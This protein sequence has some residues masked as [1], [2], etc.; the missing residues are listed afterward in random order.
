VIG[1]TVLDSTDLVRQLWLDNHFYGQIASVQYKN[2]GDELTM[3]GGWT[4]YTGTHYGNIQWAQFG[5][6]EPGYQYYSYPALKTDENIYAKWQ[7]QLNT[8]WQTFADVQ[9][10]HVYHRM[11]GFEGA[12]TLNVSRTFNFVNPKAGI[13][14][15]KKGWQ[16]FFS[17]AL[18]NK[19]P[20]RDD[21]QASLISQPKAEMLHDFELGV[22]KKNSRYSYGA[23]VYYML[24]KDQLVLTGKQ[25]D[26][27]AYTRVNVPN[28][29]RLGIELQGGYVFD[30][31]INATANLTLSKNKVKDFTEYLDDYDNGGQVA[32]NHHNTDIS[33]SPA[34]IGSAAI[35]IVPVKSLEI[36]L[37]SKYVSK[38]YLDNTQNNDRITRAF[39]TEDVRASFTVKNFLLKEWDIIGQV[40][41]V[42]NKLYE[43]GGSAYPYY[44]GGAVVND[45]Y[46]SPMAGTNYMIAVNIKL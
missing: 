6:V 16:V 46:Y 28:S 27:G 13:T 43:P 37:L 45:N 22:E 10:R 36:S 44:Y 24:Y 14:Y 26:V 5:G 35:N 42:F 3:G 4:R 20:N 38:Q 7:H 18:G 32:I 8:H 25:N 31:W 2:K 12:P 23:T 21:F 1:S 33:Y 11:T 34:V 41:N 40:N 19:E 15:S 29:Y 39:Y 9:Y 17:Y 30:K